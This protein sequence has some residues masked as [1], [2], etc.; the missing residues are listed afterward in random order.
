MGK[1]SRRYC[2]KTAIRKE[3]TIGRQTRDDYYTHTE[4]DEEE[5]QNCYDKGREEEE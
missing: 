3:E 2:I 4:D 5:N 1:Q